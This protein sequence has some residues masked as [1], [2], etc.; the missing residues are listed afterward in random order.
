MFKKLF[1][2]SM[3]VSVVGCMTVRDYDSE[4]MEFEQAN[5]IKAAQADPFKS[6]ATPDYV[7]VAEDDDVTIEVIKLKPIKGPQNIDLQVWTANAIN[8][9]KTS[10]CVR[11]DWKLMDFNWETSLPYEFLLLDN[12][13]LKIGTMTQTIWSFD[14]AAIAIPPSGYVDKM[15]IRDADLDKKTNKLTCEMVEEDIQE[16]GSNAQN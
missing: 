4:K 14:G 6:E 11:I 9:A 15:K 16:P 8:H 12:E 13:V 3:L 7:K 5:K 2:V 10:K 1:V